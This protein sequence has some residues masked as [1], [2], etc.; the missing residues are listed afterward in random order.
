MAD[1]GFKLTVEGE[2][3]FKRALKEIDAALKTNRAELKLAT[4]QYKASDGSVEALAEM[5]KSLGDTID[6][7]KKKLETQRAQY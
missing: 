1:A 3:E 2:K 6:A 5:Q 4:E 7:Q